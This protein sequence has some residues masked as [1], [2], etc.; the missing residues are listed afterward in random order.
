M[1]CK[2]PGC[3][4]TESCSDVEPKKIAKYEDD[5][6]VSD[7]WGDEEALHSAHNDIKR[8]HEKQGYL[9][10]LS[11]AKESALQQGFDES[12]PKGAELGITVGKIIAQVKCLGDEDL[13]RQAMTELNITKV[14]SKNH[15]DDNLDMKPIHEVLQ[16]WQNVVNQH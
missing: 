5:L 3:T 11:S 16:K 13:F 10:G 15:F 8:A 1:T 12:Y 9:D 14:L 6:D 4:D 2:R 7:I